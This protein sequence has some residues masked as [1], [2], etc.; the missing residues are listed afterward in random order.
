MRHD[1][2][3]GDLQQ[4]PPRKPLALPPAPRAR[5][6]PH[7]PRSTALIAPPGFALKPMARRIRAA[8]AAVNLAAV[9]TP[10]QQHLSTAARAHK[11]T[12]GVHVDQPNTP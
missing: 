2:V 4:R 8:T 9:T 12:T 7:A 10:A 3:V 11:P 5:R 1:V 6:M